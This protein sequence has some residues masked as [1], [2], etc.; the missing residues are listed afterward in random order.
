MFSIFV[1]CLIQTGLIVASNVE[2]KALMPNVS[3]QT[4]DLYLCHKV[5]LDEDKPVYI[6]EFAAKSTKEIAHHIL[7]FACADAGEEDT[8]NCGEM[9]HKSDNKQFKTGPVCASRQ[10][11]IFAW[12]LDA[13]KLVLPKDV[14]FKLGGD[15][16]NKYLVVQVHYANIDNFKDGSTDNSGI[17]LKGQYE[18]LSKQ[19]GVYLMGTGGHIK[20]KVTEKFE[21][22]CEIGEDVEMH[23]FAYRTHAHKLAL[24]NSGY[25]V[26]N[27]EKGQQTWT[28]IGRRSPQL[29]QMFYP[30]S[31]DVVVRK[32]DI[33]AARCTMYNFRDNTVYIGATG[34]DEMC[35]FYIMYWVNGDRLVE[36]NTCYS[37]GPPFWHFKN[38]R[39]ND[40][41]KALNL[42]AIP[43]NASE[44]PEA[45]QEELNRMQQSGGMHGMH[46]SSSSSGDNSNNKMEET[47]SN[48]NHMEDRKSVV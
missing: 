45:Q 13:P 10:N 47:H 25:L 24:V 23:P 1:L 31:N 38:F 6:T 29:P 7:L 9:S 4:P 44:V 16:S 32:G 28:E 43:E 5:K 19:A 22:A 48:M 41:S 40:G 27:D 36:S 18:P 17:I 14:A 2:I 33:L 37:G 35:N 26:K 39:A 12:A 46:H 20:P 21:A 3:P 42:E 15:T 34:N 11:I 30:A 8:W